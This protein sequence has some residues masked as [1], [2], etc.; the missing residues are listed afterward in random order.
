VTTGFL[1]RPTPEPQRIR[2]RAQSSERGSI[3]R[4]STDGYGLSDPRIAPRRS[5]EVDAPQVVVTVLH[6]LAQTGAI[7]AEVVQDAIA[8]FGIDTDRPDPRTA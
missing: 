6:S 3:C 1:G 5:F 4:A 7:K 8:H 2:A